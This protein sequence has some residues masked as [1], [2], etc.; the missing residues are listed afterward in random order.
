MHTLFR[1]IITIL[2]FHTTIS[3]HVVSHFFAKHQGEALHLQFDVGY[4]I[5]ET[6]DN[7]Y[8]PAPTRLWLQSRDESQHEIL[9]YESEK[10]LRTCLEFRQ[11]N[12]VIPLAISFPDFTSSPPSFTKLLNER[13]YYRIIIKPEKIDLSKTL[14]LHWLEGK[15]PDLVIEIGNSSYKTLKPSD[16]FTMRADVTKTTGHIFW[17]EA[18]RQGF[19]HVIPLGIDHILFITGMFF[20][21]R[22][23]RLLFLQ[24]L[25]FT[26]AHTITLGIVSAGLIKFSLTWVEPLIALSIVYLAVENLL[27]RAKV[28]RV[29]LGIVAIFGLIHGCG[30]AQALSEW[31]KQDDQFT[32][33]LISV[34]VG[35]EVAQ[36]CIL[37][38]LWYSTQKWWQTKAYLHVRTFINLFIA[39]IGIIWT[40][41]RVHLI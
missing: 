6:R 38:V 24:S 31:I 39:L 22:N 36:V 28:P 37:L 2:V 23:I 1:H 9:R 8:E 35:V 7:P 10:F 40:L 5:P 30:F 34:N 32:I 41:Q 17:V 14:E 19:L 21:S 4:A 27:S 29:R 13:A 11:N 20:F 16:H 3:A 12:Q 33:A 18:F 15:H 25:C 26:I